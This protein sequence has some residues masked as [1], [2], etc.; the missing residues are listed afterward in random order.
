MF[1]RIYLL[2]GLAAFMLVSPAPIHSWHLADSTLKPVSL[3]PGMH[4]IAPPDS[5]DFDGDGIPEVLTLTKGQA[6]IQSGG[7]VRWKSPQAWQVRQA[8]IADLNRD[9]LMEAV[10]L[11]WRPFKPWPVDNWLPHGGRIDNFHDSDGMSCHL[12]LIG[13]SK[14]SFRERWAGSALAEPIESFAVADLTGSGEQF[15][16]TLES[17][18]DDP[19][20]APARLLK[21]WEW[22]GFGFTVVSKEAGLFSQLVIARADNGQM[23]ILVP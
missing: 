6:A 20:S 2:L 11:V 12:I 14:N 13:W 1:R 21:V 8:R 22:N 4:P 17:G 5:V 15:L 10:L 7:Q 16:V 3:P 9:G 18:Y 19:P 23:L